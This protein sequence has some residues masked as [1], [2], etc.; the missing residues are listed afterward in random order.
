[1]TTLTNNLSGSSLD[2]PDTPP[3]TSPIE[4]ILEQEGDLRKAID[5]FKD[6]LDDLTDRKKIAERLAV[7]CAQLDHDNHEGKLSF[8]DRNL[9]MN[10]ITNNFLE[11]LD[12]LKEKIPKMLKDVDL[13]FMSKAITEQKDLI[14]YV[15]SHVLANEYDRFSFIEAGDSGWYYQAIKKDETLQ[16]P[17]VLK[18]LKIMQTADLKEEELQQ[19][20]RFDHPGI[21][22]IADYR[23]DRLPAYVL[24]EYVNGITLS[25]AFN[26]FGGFPLDIAL[27]LMNQI[28]EAYS[29]IR[30]R[31]IIHKNIRPSKIFIDHEGRAMVSSLDIIQYDKDDLRSVSR[32]KEECQYLSQ[33]A[34]DDTLDKE[35]SKEVA[36]SDQFSL[37]LLLL[38]MIGCKPLFESDRVSGIF[39][40]RQKFIE[41]P[42]AVLKTALAN[43]NIP[44]RLRSIIK[45]ML[46]ISPIERYDSLAEVIR[47]LKSI[48]TYALSHFPLLKS[49]Q[50]CREKAP[51]WARSF[52]TKLFLALP[53]IE[54]HFRDVRRQQMMLWFAVYVVIDID[55]KEAYFLR[56]LKSPKHGLYKDLYMFEIF[57]KTMKDTLR[58][59][60]GEGWDET[61]MSEPWDR[62]IQKALDLVGR[63]LRQAH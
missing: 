8:E 44:T 49:F 35:N 34:L 9:T 25:E 20:V 13:P 33:E 59:H 2:K 62:N 56:I 55:Q 17:H 18:V 61:T 57:L 16:K 26:L 5:R 45:K 12:E 41:N 63:H 39:S 47:E 51:E 46:S 28:I 37:G 1:M 29:Y 4:D 52:Y 50:I 21:V 3:T 30:A 58:K 42:N 38:E 36:R 40:K 53:D 6:F 22:R 10:R 54:P 32:F 15:I 14:H 23:F 48:E 7:N 24:L 31:N 27:D 11:I 19:V 60:A 43:L